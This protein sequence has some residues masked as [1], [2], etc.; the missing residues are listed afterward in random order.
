MAG[1]SELT[2]KC[3][4]CGG[5]LK[6]HSYGVVKCSC[7]NTIFKI[8]AKDHNVLNQA[9]E[10]RLNNSFAEA[11]QLYKKILSQDPNFPEA[12]WGALL[13]E[14]GVEYINEN[15][16]L[17]PTI[18]RPVHNYKISED[19]FALALLNNTY[20]DEHDS[21]LAKINELESLRLQIE[22]TCNTQPQ[23]D[24]FLSCK[25]TKADA[26]SEEKT[27]EYK[28]AE[29]V[30]KK[31]TGRGLKV[32]FSP[33]S[34]PATNGAYEPIIY[35][36]L[37][38][39]KYLVVFASSAQNITSKWIKNEWER[40]LEIRKRD[41]ENIR[42]YKLVIDSSFSKDVPEELKEVSFISHDSKQSWLL[43]VEKAVTE[44]FP[45]LK[46]SKYGPF[47]SVIDT[48]DL[49]TIKQQENKL[50]PSG[51]LIHSPGTMLIL[52]TNPY[53][54]HYN[55]LD[56]DYTIDDNVQVCVRMVELQLR[57]KQF[58]DAQYELNKYLNFV[59]DESNLD[60]HILVLRML[61][62]SKSTSI[63]DFYENRLQEFSDFELFERIVNKLPAN[64][65]EDFLTPFC[66]YI[67][68]SIKN[69]KDSTNAFDYYRI[70]AN[71]NVAFIKELNYKVLQCLPYIYSKPQLLMDYA[72]VVIP[73]I[74]SNNINDYIT[75]CS[76][77]AVG[78]C[79]HAL[80]AEAREIT[81]K[82]QVADAQNSKIALIALMIENNSRILDD[83]MENIEKRDAYLEIE[84]IIPNLYLTGVTHLISVIKT[85]IM[86][87]IDTL[88]Y[89][90]A[91]QWADIVA[92]TNFEGRNEYFDSLID[93]CKNIPQS[94]PVFSVVIHTIEEDRKE[95]FIKSILV[96][97]SNLLRNGNYSLARKYCKEAIEYDVDNV[98]ILN[99]Y[100]C[101][102]IESASMSFENFY[103]LT[104]FSVIERLLL[105]RET[106][107]AR[108]ELLTRF[109]NSC[110]KYLDKN[111]V[112]QD[113]NVF[114]IFDRLLT[115]F[116]E[117]NNN[118]KNKVNLF[119]EKCLQQGLFEKSKWYYIT[120]I[121]WDK[122]YHQAYWGIILA[123]HQCRTNDELIQV[124]V[125]IDSLPEYALAIMYSR[126]NEK[127]ENIYSNVLSQ[128][129]HYKKKKQIPKKI[130]ILGIAIVVAGIVAGILLKLCN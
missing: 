34:L 58:R 101:A 65:A 109:I 75:L 106:E 52:P 127:Y 94:E 27:E 89:N 93:K 44:C 98:E 8:E 95:Y 99:Y 97:V 82:L 5:L 12:N 64:V 22:T 66:T 41:I 121:R 21:Y 84:E 55:E 6:S 30:Y 45:K 63:E 86:Y 11:L 71:V 77:L 85:R 14:Y 61:I 79:K 17:V 36:A 91:A 129:L 56:S 105:T 74:S 39:S 72:R 62:E 31:L 42:H 90:T 67:I 130:I 60:Y 26:K 51:E 53:T 37:Q 111:K 114:T 102:E 48:V 24:V 117:I 100:L 128:Q 104:D 123:D 13:S 73:F 47:N 108:Q 115:Y 122:E 40:F 9:N 57:I 112:E 50:L 4:V 103:K 28:W 83:L 15:G 3:P 49:S 29:L 119:A 81:E 80:W 120:L 110:I 125:P 69:C 87:L 38:S 16:V 20:G 19:K 88:Q 116:T 10:L 126:G 46:D 1:I 32:F 43:A 70:I 113:D 35:S 107:F 23:Y 124:R 54:I 78:L 76:D 92:K 25:I 7:C 118:L 96:F 33:F 18:H 2:T 59:N 68:E